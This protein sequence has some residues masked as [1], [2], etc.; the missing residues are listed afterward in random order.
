MGTVDTSATDLCNPM[1][2]MG[3]MS[4]GTGVTNTPSAQTFCRL[5][6]EMHSIMAVPFTGDPE[7]DFVLGMI[8]HH[9]AAVDMC[10]AFVAGAGAGIAAGLASLCDDVAAGQSAEIDA[11]YAFLD[12]RSVACV[13]A[14]RG[15][16][17]CEAGI[18][19]SSLGPCG[20]GGMVMGCG[21]TTSPNSANL[22]RVG[23]IMHRGMAV[24][25]TGDWNVDFAAAMI[26]HHVGAKD[27]CAVLLQFTSSG[28]LDSTLQALCDNII[29]AQSDE[30][31]VM[32]DYLIHQCRASLP[33]VD[34]RAA[35]GSCAD[36]SFLPYDENMDGRVDITDLLGLLGRFNVYC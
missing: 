34:C 2:M 29:T 25:F 1:M 27:M 14:P 5:N 31:S 9:A 3:G 26:P 22:C 24:R 7:V 11:M 10:N 23:H 17:S 35:Q 19:P 32:E 18:D 28:S 16:C 21:D 6:H 30:I 8:P 13:P 4:M 36:G 15:N 33:S 12:S 20:M